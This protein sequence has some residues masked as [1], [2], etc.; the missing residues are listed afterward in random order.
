MN[1]LILKNLTKTYANGVKALTNISL[2]LTNGMFGLLGPNGAGKSSL[3]KTL[4]RL[5]DP[6]EGQIIFNGTD[7]VKDPN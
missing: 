7:I 5:Q 1:T 6:D 2:E 4:A 3:M